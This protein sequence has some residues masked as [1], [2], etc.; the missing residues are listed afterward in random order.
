MT[1]AI[2]LFDFLMVVILVWLAWW[3]LT[4]EDL[5]KAV[6]LFIVFGLMAALTY[7]R[8]HAIDVALTEAA[9]GSGITGVLFLN[10]LRR[11]KN[12]NKRKI[13]ERKSENEYK[14]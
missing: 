4:T 1:E 5:F 6:I 8:L 10:A 2:R 9:V 7:G 12:K 13:G 14:G 11:L 3:L